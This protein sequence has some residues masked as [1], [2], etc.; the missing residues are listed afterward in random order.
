MHF[1]I[2]ALDFADQFAR[3]KRVNSGLRQ[4]PEHADG[5]WTAFRACRRQL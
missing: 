5:S 2:F 1:A 3:D 4:L